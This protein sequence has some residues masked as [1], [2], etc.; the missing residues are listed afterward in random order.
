M[1]SFYIDINAK[2]STLLNNSNNRFR[3]ELPNSINLPTGTQITCLQSI[4]NQ[5]GITGASISIDETITEKLIVQYYMKDTDY[6]MPTP[7]L[8]ETN[9]NTIGSWDSIVRIN[10]HLNGFKYK[11]FPNFSNTYD[12]T[13][14]LQARGNYGFFSTENNEIGG[15]EIP[16]PLLMSCGYSPL[17]GN[18]SVADEYV[19]PFCGEIEIIINKG[20]YSV[21]D[22][23]QLITEQINGVKLADFKNEN[24]IKLQIDPDEPPVDL[25]ANAN[26]TVSYRGFAINNT[27]CRAI[28]SFTKGEATNFEGGGAFRLSP[29]QFELAGGAG[30]FNVPPRPLTVRDNIIFDAVAFHPEFATGARK[31]LIQGY[32]GD[33]ST[34]DAYKVAGLAARTGAYV[35]M[36]NLLEAKELKGTDPD[37]SYDPTSSGI[38]VGATNFSLK[39][40]EDGGYF[41]LDHLH[42]GRFIPTYDRFGN[43]MDSSGQ[44][45][46]FIKRVSGQNNNARTNQAPNRPDDNKVLPEGWSKTYSQP[47]TSSGG[48][49][50]LNWAYNTAKK[51]G[52]KPPIEGQREDLR[53]QIPDNILEGIDK[54]RLYDEWFDDNE[55]A[56]EAWEKT[57]WYKL[58]FT[59]NDIQKSQNFKP[60]FQPDAVNP[61]EIVSSRV[62]G[63]T[64]TAEIDPSLIPTISTMYNGQGHS[65]SEPSK[66][67]GIVALNATINGIQTYNNLDV[68]VPWDLFN[69]NKALE[70]SLGHTYGG[71]KGS[72][73]TGAVM[74]PV[75]TTPSP[76]RASRLPILS[77]NGYMIISTDLVEQ[78]DV[79][80]NKTNLGI[81]DLIPKSNLNNQDYVA[82]RNAL[83]HTLSNPKIINSINIDILNP[84]LTD[85]NLEPN[86]SL[87]LQIITPTPKQTILLQMK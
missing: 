26:Y 52:T 11:G 32:V 33:L 15:T 85:I 59:Y 1:S 14:P 37:L 48:I 49:M 22:L 56:E 46:I 87:L 44:E 13:E 35:Q 6:F 61:Q 71:Y 2:N 20:T 79:V 18:T 81:I 27:T 72:F 76:F 63:F 21:K 69:N 5:Q 25:P 82:D 67:G 29:Y 84:D 34:P 8:D 86:S 62:E 55:K 10:Q 42:S 17:N 73:Y 16:M 30:S 7:K 58:G 70:A 65:S 3:Y 24:Y 41:S 45:C 60:F 54:F 36:M 57:L 40:D 53:Q 78:N 31:N 83:T 77:D 68:N 28:K 47:M 19:I 4:I 9:A 66:A 38:G 74:I 12:A 50:V 75:I 39:Y 43:K 51:Y 80:K 23:S 64:T